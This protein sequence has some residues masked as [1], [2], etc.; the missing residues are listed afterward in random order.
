MCIRCTD[1]KTIDFRT[2]PIKY[3]IKAN[4]ERNIVEALDG[5]VYRIIWYKTHDSYIVS[6]DF[7][8]GEGKDTVNFS[9]YRG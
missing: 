8:Y 2:V 5:P 7:S 1:F 3:L 4:L 9:F 6:F